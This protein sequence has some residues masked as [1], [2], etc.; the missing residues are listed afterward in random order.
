MHHLSSGFLAFVLNALSSLSLERPTPGSTQ[1][2]TLTVPAQVQLFQ[3]QRKKVT[4]TARREGFH[5]KIRLDFFSLPEG[6]TIE[7]EKGPVSLHEGSHCTITLRANVDAPPS[8]GRVTLTARS[9]EL[10]F[11]PVEITVTIKKKR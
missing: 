3:G 6:V 1:S 11:G 7:A 2:L 9:G 10:T 8:R 5:E 4:I